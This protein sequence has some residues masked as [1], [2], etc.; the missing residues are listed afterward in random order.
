[1]TYGAKK[2]SLFFISAC[3]TELPWC[4]Y[5][6]LEIMTQNLLC[7]FPL[8]FQVWY[9]GFYS[10]VFCLSSWR[11]LQGSAKFLNP[12]N[13]A[14]LQSRY[15]DIRS[16][17]SLTCWHPFT[18]INFEASWS[19]SAKKF[20][21]WSIPPVH[22]LGVYVLSEKVTVVM[23]PARPQWYIHRKHNFIVH[24]PVPG[25]IIRTSKNVWMC[26]LWSFFLTPVLAKAP[27]PSLE[28][29]SFNQ[30]STRMLFL[31]KSSSSPEVWKAGQ[32]QSD[33]NGS[34]ENP[35]L[36]IKSI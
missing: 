4:L 31:C 8:L 6:S 5:V 25:V 27:P 17:C 15:L 26:V 11:L 18:G 23:K 7:F 13:K 3:T 29:P 19:Q 1:M 24:I 9:F 20:A 35:N 32:L 36:E 10:G 21:L 30:L 33:P 34:T 28:S 2:I 14:R 16:G 12:R 22:G